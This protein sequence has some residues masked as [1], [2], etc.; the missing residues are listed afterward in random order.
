MNEQVGTCS[1]CGSL[2]SHTTG[3]HYWGIRGNTILPGYPKPVTDFGFPLSVT[4]VDAAV[5]VTLTSRT[6]LFVNNK[7]WRCVM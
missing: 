1:N 7:Y 4:K 2:P 5:Y 6:L 3:A